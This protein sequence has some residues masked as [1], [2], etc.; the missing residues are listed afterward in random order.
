MLSRIVPFLPVLFL[1]ATVVGA[2]FT[3]NALRPAQRWWPLVGPGFFA[4]WIT[5]ELAP[6][7]LFWQ[8]IATALFVWAGALA[9]WPGWVALAVVLGSWMGLFFLISEARRSRGVVSAA[10]REQLGD[11]YEDQIEPAR[12]ALLD[13]GWSL[14]QR[15]LPL[16]MWDARVEH[17]KNI[18]FHRAGGVN[19]RLDIYRPRHGKG[20]FPTILHVHGGAWMIGSKDDQGKPLAHRMAAHGWVV[21]SAN[22]RLSPRFAWPD[23]IVDVKAAIRWIKEHGAEYGADPDFIAITG[24]SAGGH[25]AALAALTPNDPAFQPGFEQADTTVQACVPFYGVYDFTDRRGHW[26]RSL[27]RPMLEHR[28]VKKRLRDDF[29]VFDKASPMSRVHPG[30]PPFF[31]IHGT[32]DTMVPIAEART[33]VELL[34]AASRA[35][36]LFAELPGAQHAFEIFPS[37]RTGHALMGV[38]RFLAWTYSVWREKRDARG[39]TEAARDSK[40]VLHHGDTGSTE[41]PGVFLVPEKESP[42]ALEEN[43]KTL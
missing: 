8:A 11:G 32:R 16:P 33:F 6:H 24:G 13:E 27:L 41:P 15:L 3:M 10:L 30:A 21:V 34:R 37:E 40:G 43:R 26:K 36:V 29:E 39:H 28:I 20:P 12:R 7:H 38:E 35:P 9:G 5:G 2:M 31:V 4:S 42:F 17:L 23:H 18:V 1:L 22:Y 14:R 25:L 19:L